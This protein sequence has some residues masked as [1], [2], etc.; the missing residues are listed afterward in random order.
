MS[1]RRGSAAGLA[2]C[3]TPGIVGRHGAAWK[4]RVAAPPEDGKA[5]DAVVRL[6]A[7]TLGCPRGTSTIVSGHASRDKIVALPGIDADEIER[8][9]AERAARERTP[10]THASRPTSSGRCSRP[11]ATGSRR[12]RVPRDGDRGRRGRARRARRSRRQP[13]RRHGVG[14][15]RPRARRRARG[16]RAADARRRST[17]ALARLD[18][19]TYGICERLRQADRRR[20]PARASRGR[21]SASTTSGSPTAVDG[22]PSSAAPTSA[23]ARRRTALAPV[24]VARALA[25]ARAPGSGPAS[26]RS[27][28]PRSSATR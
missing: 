18:D 17:R 13:S 21:R 23:S 4:I 19:G 2:R 26:P 7:E 14:H 28:S 11:S 9:L 15:L 16:G 8:R 24:S 20:A 6:L 12:D 22:A 1:A 5:N 27:R 3:R 10:V 25:R